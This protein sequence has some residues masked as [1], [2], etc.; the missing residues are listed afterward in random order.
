MFT[1]FGVLSSS[2][3]CKC[4]KLKKRSKRSMIQII[5]LYYTCTF[6]KYNVLCSGLLL[7]ILKNSSFFHLLWYKWFDKNQSLL[8]FQIYSSSSIYICNKALKSSTYTRSGS[9]FVSRRR[10]K[11]SS[12]VLHTTADERQLYPNVTYAVFE[13]SIRSFSLHQ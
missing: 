6:H 9:G 4:W 12:G 2:R 1:G 3:L 13:T 11:Y 10:R 8:D 5:K 7:E